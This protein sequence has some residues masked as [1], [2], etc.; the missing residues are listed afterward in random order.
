MEEQIR[1]DNPRPYEIPN[2]QNIAAY[3]TKCLV[4]ITSGAAA[5]STAVEGPEKASRYSIP[6][7]Y[8]DALESLVRKE[9]LIK[10]ATAEEKILDALKF[11]SDT[12]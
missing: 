3:V 7:A 9:P 5:D 10:P 12:K 1:T 2:V 6:V 4:A 11:T 8:A